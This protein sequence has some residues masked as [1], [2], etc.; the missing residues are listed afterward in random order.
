MY[1]RKAVYRHRKKFAFA[2]D[3][4]QV[5]LS[6][7][8]PTFQLRSPI[9]PAIIC[10]HFTFYFILWSLWSIKNRFLFNR[11][12]LAETA[13]YIF[14]NLL[15]LNE[16]GFRHLVLGSSCVQFVNIFEYLFSLLFYLGCRWHEMRLQIDALRWKSR[17]FWSHHR[18]CGSF[19]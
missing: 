14:N 2:S 7:F 12:Y 19:S 8:S 9:A 11:L 4:L 6:F 13:I 15:H 16:A 17:F 3:L 5:F 1:Y 18:N 10:L